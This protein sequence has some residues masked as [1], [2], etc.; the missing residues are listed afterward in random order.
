MP[1]PQQ[2]VSRNADHILSEANG[3]LSRD[4]VTVKAGEN[5]KA[6]Q[7][8]EDNSGEMIA[9]A[10][11]TCIGVLYQDSDATDEAQLAVAHVRNCELHES[12]LI[13]VT[14]QATTDLAAINI[15]VRA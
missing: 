10:G 4:N 1:N 6:G 7:L 15:I 3:T 2:L 8:L 9:L 14:P 11:G 5:L 12:K 13:G